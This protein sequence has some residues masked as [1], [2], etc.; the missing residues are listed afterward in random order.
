MS[1]ILN[2][3]IQSRTQDSHSAFNE[4]ETLNLNPKVRAVAENADEDGNCDR[5]YHEQPDIVA[6]PRFKLPFCVPS[7]INFEQRIRTGRRR[8]S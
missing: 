2:D 8:I 3:D 6:N 4:E 5:K 7:L 1:A